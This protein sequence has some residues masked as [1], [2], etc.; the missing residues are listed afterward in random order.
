VT[1]EM[2]IAFN[3]AGVF[4]LVAGIA[5]GALASNSDVDPSYSASPPGSGWSAIPQLSFASSLKVFWNVSDGTDGD[6]LTQALRHG[7]SPLT[8][9]NTYW[10]YP[11]HQEENIYYFAKRNKFNPW[12]MPPYFERVIRRNISSS[13]DVGYFVHDIELQFQRDAAEAWNTPALR[14]ASEMRTFEEF[15]DA[16]YRK[17]DSWYLWPLK[18]T[19]EIYPH[20]KVG[21][22][23]A[24]PFQRD[25]WGIARSSEQRFGWL[26]ANDEKLWQY[27]D[28]FVDF[29]LPCIYVYFDEP[30]SVFYMA[31]N[32]EESYIRTR[33][34]GNKPVFAYTWLRF[35]DGNQSIIPRA[36]ELPSYL[37]EAMAIVPYF[38]G[39]TGLVLW[40]YEPSIKPGDGLPYRQLPLFVNSLKRVADLSDKI[41]RAKPTFDKPARVLWKEKLPLV[42]KLVVTNSECVA[43]AINPWQGENEESKADLQ[44]G[45]KTYSLAMRGRHTTIAYINENSVSEY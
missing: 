28:P 2:K 38:S 11:G 23:G 13:A 27:I 21:V 6:N 4:L 41:A 32:V 42:R 12:L 45:G 20:T 35:D 10:D 25:I 44:C 14:A 40:G 37:V 36:R 29:Y 15:E 39:A 31:T 19:K 43:I 1:I 3:K 17:V 30:G 22:F 24:Y 9:I 5:A 26:H 18:W 8:L 33:K 34:F 7:F 16:Y